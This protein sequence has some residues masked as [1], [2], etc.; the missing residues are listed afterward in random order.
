M[1]IQIISFKKLCQL[2]DEQRELHDVFKISGSGPHSVTMARD[3]C[4][5]YDVA[6]QNFGCRCGISVSSFQGLNRELG[7]LIISKRGVLQ[8]V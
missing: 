1:D 6:L 3:D 7:F 2:I 8:G 5:G 4:H